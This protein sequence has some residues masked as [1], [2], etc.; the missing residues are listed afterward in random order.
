MKLLL[1]SI[2]VCFGIASLLAAW[3]F[4]MPTDASADNSYKITSRTVPDDFRQAYEFLE[5]IKFP[6][7]PEGGFEAQEAPRWDLSRFMS[8]ISAEGVIFSD[9]NGGIS[10]RRSPAQIR[11]ALTQRKGAVFKVFAHLAHIY[12][13]PYKQYSELTFQ[14]KDKSFIV[15]ISD[16]YSLTFASEGDHLRLIKCDYLEQEGD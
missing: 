15:N 6:K 9:V 11:S 16:W 4:S 2:F 12:S 13:I 5:F 10:G 1:K 7:E 8:F 14:K 3:N